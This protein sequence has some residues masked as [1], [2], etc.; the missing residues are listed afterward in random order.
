M[1]KVA[2]IEAYPVLVN[3]RAV[4]AEE[5]VPTLSQFDDVLVAVG[6]GGG[7]KSQER[8]RLFLNPF[9]DDSLFGYFREGRGSR[10]L[11]IRSEA[12]EFVPVN[13]LAE[14][15]TMLETEISGEIGPDGIIRSGCRG[16]WRSGTWRSLKSGRIQTF[17]CAWGFSFEKDY[18]S[19]SLTVAYDAARSSVV[20][21]KTM[22][23]KK[24]EIGTAEYQE[25]KKIMESFGTAKTNL[26]L[27]TK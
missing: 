21:K 1:L 16:K 24:R 14:A 6:G 2:G 7:E 22:V 25:F 18:G 4:P 17:V 12:V 26:I 8:G 11:E 27:L 20:V 15:E 3:S 5:D 19:F 9:A 13:C 10:G 23:F